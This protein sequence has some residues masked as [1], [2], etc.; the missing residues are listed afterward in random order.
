MSESYA[1]ARSEAYA[2][3]D[4]AFT[5]AMYLQ[6]LKDNASYDARDLFTQLVKEGPT[7]TV[8][9]Q[10]V[11]YLNTDEAKDAL[12]Q[13][14]RDALK[15]YCMDER[16]V[17]KAVEDAFYTYSATLLQAVYDTV[18]DAMRDAGQNWDFS[19]G[20][21]DFDFEDLTAGGYKAR[22]TGYQH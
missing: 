8:S 21:S 9:Q 15:D 17:S 20:E 19:D 1:T 18:Q 2:D 11:D 10:F 7:G 4:R 12:Q 5:A 22:P 6:Y 16:V 3:I 13:A 14:V